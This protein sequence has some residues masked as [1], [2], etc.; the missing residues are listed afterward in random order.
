MP[1]LPKRPFPPAHFDARSNGCLGRIVLKN[2][3]RLP[4][5]GARKIDLSDR[6]INRSQ[7]IDHRSAYKPLAR[8]RRIELLTAT[9]AATPRTC[10]SG[11]APPKYPQRYFPAAAYPPIRS[12]ISTTW[13]V[14][15]CRGH[16]RNEPFLLTI[17]FQHRGAAYCRRILT[18]VTCK[19]HCYETPYCA[20]AAR[21]RKK[22]MLR[23]R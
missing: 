19:E 20:R 13:D 10:D 14:S 23:G 16:S 6:R 22:K 3:V 21:C 7:K 5:R 11:D 2:P 12:A 17:C 9:R 18:I 4:V 1:S 8:K 15:T